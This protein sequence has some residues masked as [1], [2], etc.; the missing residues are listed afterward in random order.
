MKNCRMLYFK[1]LGDDRGAMIAIENGNN[2]PFDIKRA[3]YIYD[4]KKNVARG[5]HA[6]LNLKQ[7]AIALK[8]S[9]TF[10]LDD[11][12]E[13]Q[14]IELNNPDEGL[15]IDGIIWREMTDF[16]DDCILLVLASEYYDES[17]YIRDYGKFLEI[18]AVS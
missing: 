1:N 5:F 11:G 13:R 4:T 8:G 18:S 16:S 7:I 12:K 6:H 2:S 17:D 14:H 9:C 15:L 10:I 3:Y